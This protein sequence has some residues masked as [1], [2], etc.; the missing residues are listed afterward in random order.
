MVGTISCR[1]N[2]MKV[3]QERVKFRR[4]D[5]GQSGIYNMCSTIHLHLES[6]AIGCLS[7]CS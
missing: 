1:E 3:W 6:M 2:E 5:Y 4:T 7:I